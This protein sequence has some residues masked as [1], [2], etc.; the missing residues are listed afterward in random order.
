[1]STVTSPLR[2]RRGLKSQDAGFIALMIGPTLAAFLII[3]FIPIANAFIYSFEKRNLVSRN[4]SFIGLGNYVKVLSDG[5]FWASLSNTLLYTACASLLSVAFG[6]IL[7]YVINERL[8]RANVS[9][10]TLLF[11]PVIVSLVPATLMW[12]ILFDYNFGYINF[13]ISLLGRPK[14]DWINNPGNIIVPIIIVSVWKYMGYNMIIFL[15][16]LKAIPSQ[17]VDA[18]SIDGAGRFRVFRSI[19]LPLLKPITLF[20]I[21]ISVIKDLKLFTEAFVMSS[22]SQSSGDIYKTSVYYIYQQAFVYFDIGV[23]TAASVLFLFLVMVLTI[24][25]FRISKD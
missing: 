17:Y 4:V 19:L 13:L 22:G 14:I 18:A 6:F 10:Q 24:L 21:V 12:K 5:V 23:G 9:L 3:R 16:G 25:Q 7:A 20:V 8:L 2:R 11:L 1:M 15:V